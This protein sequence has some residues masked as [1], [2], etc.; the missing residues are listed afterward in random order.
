MVDDIL[1]LFISNLKASRKT[2]SLTVRGERRPRVFE[3]RM[4]RK[5]CRSKRD[6]G[7]QGSGEDCIMTNF[8]IGTP[9]LIF[10]R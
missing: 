2:L 1:Y 5:K 6:E 7:G 10:F 8:M 4:P 3:I 9:R